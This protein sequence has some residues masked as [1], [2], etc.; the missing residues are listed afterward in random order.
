MIIAR[1]SGHNFSMIP[2]LFLVLLVGL[3]LL[4]LLAAFIQIVRNNRELA[5]TEHKIRAMVR[6]I[7]DGIIMLDQD[8]KV[9][10]INPAAVK[11]LGLGDKPSYVFSDLE[12]VLSGKVEL[13]D[14]VEESRRE[15]KVLTFDDVLTEAGV[16]QLLVSPVHDNNTL[17]GRTV[18]LLHDMTVKRQLEH[19]HDEFTAMMV[20]E[21][22]APLTVVRGT[23]D[24]FS[25]NPAL[26][27]TEDGKNLMKTIKTS[28][29]SMLSL[30]N[31]LLDVSK[32]EAGKFQLVLVKGDFGSLI[33]DR[34][35][36][37]QEMARERT[38]SLGA[39][40]IDS[41]LEAEFDRDRSSQ[42]LNNLITNAIKFTPGG[43]TVAISAVKIQS[44]ADIK[45]RYYPVANLR[46]SRPSI[47]VMVSDTGA[48]IAG[49]EM[50]MLF[51][52]F[53]QLTAGGPHHPGTGLGLV[54]AK[55]IVES[56]G[57]Q[58]FAESKVTEGTNFY[59]TIPLG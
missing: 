59:F 15:N 34:I 32:I 36:F 41:N 29:T 17:S 27:T 54:I 39:G 12:K 24:M 11:L 38:V 9:A 40:Q 3:T 22:R 28:T 55:G 25:E 45:W 57:G 4:T 50:S 26:V 23:M 53:K 10:V 19:L 21:L 31:D 30:V 37:F 8:L 2:T 5:T 1:E 56:Q 48:G 16:T 13:K 35:S 42:V 52:K 46:I 14:K 58:I 33:V 6:S 20:H 7:V 51:S 43:G 44:E 47:L 18:L 49:E